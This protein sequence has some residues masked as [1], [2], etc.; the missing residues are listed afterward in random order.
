MVVVWVGR[1]NEALS[2]TAL[3][4]VL[5]RCSTAYVYPTLCIPKTR[6]RM[7][8]CVHHQVLDDSTKEAVRQRVDSA[9][10]ACIEEG[11]PVQVSAAAHPGW[12]LGP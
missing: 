6:T 9:A 11:H 1:Q 7:C 5:V 2:H 10:A 4:S 12:Q 8:V 3:S